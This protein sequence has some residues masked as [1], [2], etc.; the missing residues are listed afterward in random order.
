MNS[1][2]PRDILSP[3]VLTEADK[4]L[5]RMS[6]AYDLAVLRRRRVS[7]LSPERWEKIVNMKWRVNYTEIYRK[8]R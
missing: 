4:G 5:R 8:E 1:Q 7:K 2:D 6:P 3:V